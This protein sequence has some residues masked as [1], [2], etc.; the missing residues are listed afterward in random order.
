M[1]EALN[2][3]AIAVRH[4]WKR[5]GAGTDPLVALQDIDFSVRDGEFVSIVGP[6]GCGKSTLLKILA[7]LLPA[8]DGDALLR[9]T[10]IDGP[11]RDIGVVFQ[12][13][14]LFPWRSVLRQRAPA[15]RRAAARARADAAARAS[16]SWTSSVSRA[17]STATRGSC[18]AA[19]S[20]AS[21]SC[22]PSSTIPRSC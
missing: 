4:L 21:R 1:G 14:V 7:G 5:F 19:C 22:A 15:R 10:P 18:R 2:G 17:S 11:R 20:S 16:S 12:S 6:S 13:P 8:S 3:D 9:G